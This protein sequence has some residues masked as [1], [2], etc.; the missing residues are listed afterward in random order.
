VKAIA[1]A[2][3]G[4]SS[5]PPELAA[6]P[7]EGMVEGS[8]R[9][10]KERLLGLAEL[11]EAVHARY[12]DETGAGYQVFVVL[13]SGEGSSDEPWD[14]LAQLWQQIDHDAMPVLFREIPYEGLVGVMRSEAGLLGVAGV[15]TQEALLERLESLSIN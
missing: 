1:Q 15:E 12:S 9:Y 6:L 10:T 11:N 8:A 3:P 5:P 4:S 14:A 13:P 2:L 7:S